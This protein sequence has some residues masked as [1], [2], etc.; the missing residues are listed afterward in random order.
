MMSYAV[1]SKG[2]VKKFAEVFTPAG[3][4]FE[5][6]LQDGMR[7]V[8]MDVEK[9]ILDPACGEGQFPCAELVWKMFYNLDVLNETTALLALNRLYGVD[10]Q[11][12][13]VIKT[14]EHLLLTLKDAYRFFTGE[15]FTA[16][17]EARAIVDERIIEGDFLKLAKQWT[18]RNF[19]R[20]D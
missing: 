16:T 2:N 13:S 8:L 10:L 4:V 20:S 14:K 19:E 17:D 7:S 6:I 11:P 9:T 18:N 12:S 5:M 3:V 15:E 1:K